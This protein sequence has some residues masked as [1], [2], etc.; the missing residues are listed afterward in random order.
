MIVELLGYVGRICAHYEQYALGIYVWQTLLLLLAP[1]LI[2]ATIYMELGHIVIVTHKESCSPIRVSWLTK[3]FVCT[4]VLS[5][6]IQAGG[7]PPIIACLSQYIAMMNSKSNTCS[8]VVKS[9]CTDISSA[10]NGPPAQASIIDAGRN[11][12][13]SGLIFQVFFFALFIATAAIFHY[14]AALSE[15]NHTISI[16]LDRYSRSPRSDIT[17]VRNPF[18]KS[19]YTNQTV[20]PYQRHL[21]VLHFTSL[22]ILARSIFRIFEFME[23]HAGKLMAVEW[24][25]YAFD[26]VLMFGVMMTYNIWHSGRSGGEGMAKR[27]EVYSLNGR[28]PENVYRSAEKRRMAREAGRVGRTI[29]CEV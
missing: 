25:L 3:I 19:T 13:V 6:L 21:M 16:S 7:M 17:A 2:A 11:I 10:D 5:F 1:T 15:S 20:M 23:G 8:S 22:L 14:R 26:A 4:D 29:G 27:G 18:R 9:I 12:V 24:Y 28:E